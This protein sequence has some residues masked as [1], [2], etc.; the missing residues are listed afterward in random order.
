MPAFVMPGYDPDRDSPGAVW[1]REH[2]APDLQRYYCRHGRYIGFM[3]IFADSCERCRPVERTY[4]VDVEYSTHDCVKEGRTST[5]CERVAVVAV[6]EREAMLVA[7]Q[8]VASTLDVMPTM[9]TL[10]V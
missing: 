5:G 3:G 7:C 4:E 8:F 10:A 1:F 9:A 6:G 2:C